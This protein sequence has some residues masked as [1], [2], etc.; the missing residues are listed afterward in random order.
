M[1][2]DIMIPDFDQWLLAEGT[3][4]Q[5]ANWFGAHVIKQHD[6][7]HVDVRFLLYAPHAS[8]VT[9]VGDFNQWQT[10]SHRMQALGGG[11]WGMVI[12]SLSL[13]DCYQYAIWDAK[14]Q[15]LPLRADPYT[16]AMQAGAGKASLI[17]APIAP[18]AWQRPPHTSA[19][20]LSIYEVHLPSWQ[21]HADGTVYTWDDLADTLPAYVADL[22]FTHVQFMPICAHPFGGS[23]GYQPIGL[24]APMAELGDADGLKRLINACHAIGLGVILDWVAAHF[25]KDSHG[26]A[27]FDG[28]PLYESDDPKLAN[29][30]DWNTLRYDYAR[31]HVKQFLISNAYY[32]LETF[33]FDGLRLDA[34]SAMLYRD[35]GQSD[36]QWSCNIHG[37]REYLE[38]I[39]FLQT[40]TTHLHQRVSNCLLIAEEST[41]W[42]GITRQPQHRRRSKTPCSF[43]GFDYKWN[44]GWMNDTLRYMSRPAADRLQHTREITF[45]P[46]YDPSEHFILPLSHDEVVHGKGTLLTRMTGDRHE[47][48]QQLRAY[49][50]FMWAHPAKKLLFMGNEWGQDQEWNHDR[51]LDWHMLQYADHQHLQQLVQTLNQHYRSYPALYRTDGK[52]EGFIWSDYRLAQQGIVAFMRQSDLSTDCTV[53]CV[54]HFDAHAKQNLQISVNHAGTWRCILD[55]DQ[56]EARLNQSSLLISTIPNP[57]PDQGSAASDTIVTRHSQHICIDLP[58]FSTRWYVHH[59]IES[60]G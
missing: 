5:A 10:Q 11:L 19:D 40:L 52:S 26:L 49:Y 34:V 44:M 50:A 24:F 16:R 41:S 12:S 8:A 47:Q 36:H 37:G 3:H 35:Y 22:G 14:G 33:G 57:Q 27:C 15:A 18:S 28:Q 53:L 20:P 30:P 48:C 58:A 59:S 6:Q 2:I 42:Y 7:I 21:R 38:A 25:P 54:S 13:G 51:A 45:G 43:L 29:L 23:W 56:T 55:T 31:P 46:Y 17:S 32:W 4:Q 60:A 1:A 9:V 39:D